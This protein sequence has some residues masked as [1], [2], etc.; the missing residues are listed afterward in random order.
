[1]FFVVFGVEKNSLYKVELRE[2]NQFIEDGRLSIRVFWEKF[3]AYFHDMI[4]MS[5]L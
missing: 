4:Y 5:I 2:K 3:M 1:M